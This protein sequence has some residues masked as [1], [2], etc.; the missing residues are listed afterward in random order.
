MS[1]V[2]QQ[3]ERQVKAGR[4]MANRTFHGVEEQVGPVMSTRRAQVSSGV[5]LA[6]LIAIGAGLLVYRLRRRPTLVSRIE[7]AL[8]DN[9][10]PSTIKR[11]LG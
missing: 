6:V 11:A 2:T 9:L 8:P 5:V 4:H 3:I 1:G 7:K 10:R